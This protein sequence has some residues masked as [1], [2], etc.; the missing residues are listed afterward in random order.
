MWLYFCAKKGDYYKGL[1]IIYTSDRNNMC[2]LTVRLILLVNL[3]SELVHSV[4][5]TE[6]DYFDCW[7]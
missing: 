3:R 7:L 4:I 2:E 1:Q 6:K 5:K